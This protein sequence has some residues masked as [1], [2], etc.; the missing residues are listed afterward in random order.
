MFHGPHFIVSTM[1]AGTTHIFNVF[2][3]TGR[4]WTQLDATGRNWT[5][6]DATGLDW[7][8][9][10]A[11]G[12]DWTRLDATGRDWTRLD[13]AATALPVLKAHE[14]YEK[15]TI[16][17]LDYYEEPLK[18][19]PFEMTEPI[20]IGGDQLTRERF[21]SALKLSIGNLH[22]RFACL[23]PCIFEFFHLGMNYLQ[24][25]LAVVSLWLT[26]WPTLG[27]HSKVPH[28]LYCIS[29]YT[30]FWIFFPLYLSLPYKH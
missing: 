29:A 14:Q 23:N 12:R 21:G 27:K 7:T 25:S 13:P 28:T 30:V 4:D 26:L 16:K 20:Q 5:R 2:G 8:R 22:K 18:D 1:Q 11:T 17:I 24:F 9:L 6:L 19:L 10:D 15:D 3:M